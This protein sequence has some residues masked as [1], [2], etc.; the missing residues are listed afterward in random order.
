MPATKLYPPGSDLTDAYAVRTAVFVNEQGFSA[1]I[2]IDDTDPSAYHIVMFDGAKPV[3]TG[4]VFPENS[5]KQT[6][7]IG[8]VA[9]LKKYRGRGIGIKLMAKLE[10][11]AKSLGGTRTV[12]GSQ[13]QAKQFYEKLGYA[14]FGGQYMDE[15]CPHINMGKNL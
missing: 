11:C 3:A 5:D 15:H 2:E 4:R 14:A 13:M 10:E 8:R 1:E 9:V 6:Y 7:H 12:L